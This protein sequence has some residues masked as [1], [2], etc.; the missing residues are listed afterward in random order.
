MTKLEF[1]TRL[2]NEGKITNR[3][4]FDAA[5]EKWRSAGGTFSDDAQETPPTVN[6]PLQSSQQAPAAQAQ[7]APAYDPYKKYGTMGALFPAIAR[8]KDVGGGRV[9]RAAATVGDAFSM[10]PRG[11][12]AI[13]TGLGAL[14][15]GDNLSDAYDKSMEAM[16][17]TSSDKKGVLG[18]VQNIGLDPTTWVPG[19]QAVKGAK[20]LPTIGKAVV[21][22]AA[23]GGASSAYQQLAEGRI[24]PGRVA[25]QTVLGAVTGGGM[26]VAGKGISKGVSAIRGAKKAIPAPVVARPI[27]AVSFDDI[28][29][30]KA[31]PILQPTGEVV[32]TGKI[33]QPGLMW[34]K[35]LSE[36]E[37]RIMAESRAPKTIPFTEY[38][39]QAKS[40]KSDLRALN[41]GQKAATNATE[42]FKKIDSIRKA[43][44]AQID[45]AMEAAPDAKIDISD[46][47]QRYYELVNKQL[48]I[49]KSVDGAEDAF[50]LVS[51]PSALPIHKDI[52]QTLENI[53]DVLDVQTAQRLKQNIRS[54]LQYD[55]T[56]QL[57]PKNSRMSA[58]QK[59]I[60]SLVDSKLDAQLGPAYTEANSLYGE[61]AKL[62]DAFSRALGAEFTPGSGLTK[63]G[64]SIMKRAL[65]SNADSNT[66][67]IFRA[68]KKLTGGEYD[69]FQDAAYANIAM[70]LSGDANQVR[71][72]SS[73]GT[74][75]D[76]G[77]GGSG[78][79]IISGIEK[80]V[81]V[82]GAGRKKLTGGQLARIEKWYRKQHG[83]E[84]VQEVLN[85]AKQPKKNLGTIADALK[86]LKNERGAV[87]SEAVK[88]DNFKNWFGDWEKAPERA[89]KVVDE[90][91]APLKVWH[92]S[93]ADFNVFESKYM[94]KNGTSQG[95]GFYLTPDRDL[96]LGY[97][98]N[99]KAFY[100]DIK[101]P[102]NRQKKT[103]TK[104]QL[105][106]IIDTID[107]DVAKRDGGEILSNYGDV[108]YDGRY[109][110]LNK[111]VSIEYDGGVSDIDLYGSLVNSA[112]DQEA[113][114]SAFKKITGHDG[115]ISENGKE[116]VPLSNTQI[117]SATGNSGKFDPKVPDI[118]GSGAVPI[119]AGTAAAGIGG[120]TAYEKA[121]ELK[122]KKKKNYGTVADAVTKRSK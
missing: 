40:A 59:E 121:K 53:P 14:K 70:R 61:A 72:A 112:G 67:D 69:L 34:N 26:A 65:Q 84:A 60:S 45:A 106:R 19:T 108:N 21:R 104:L 54:K 31:G 74:I 94:G 79:D 56:G 76:A 29:K 13:G 7:Q 71:K 4:D 16:Q 1:V 117:K 36:A 87:G 96:A 115:I 118:R 98:K 57:R 8:Q 10:L 88:T 99:L 43:A 33:K 52:I 73:F 12:A 81:K 42:A 28:N 119:L 15:G 39:K 86:P 24:D 20:L 85:E 114:A 66:G 100:V 22:A 78:G 90:S 23:E 64:A 9:A 92:G 95:Q 46:V 2:K 49:Q 89:S 83:L 101:K 25:G 58:I 91:G 68:V 50:S 107:K 93:D 113:V 62:E 32:S 109:K 18:V 3:G 6:A 11:A 122:N 48:G 63:H 47:K 75:M 80:G 17:Q 105:M 5:L 51:D 120:L 27:E 35:D 44:G 110:V 55:A 103:V 116:I 30:G 37:T 97:G 41:P 77:R 82:M 111:A 102:L 38:A